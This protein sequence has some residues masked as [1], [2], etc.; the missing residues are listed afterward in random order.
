MICG[1]TQNA[2]Y[3]ILKQLSKRKL[4]NKAKHLGYPPK[5][6]IFST[7]QLIAIGSLIKIMRL[8]AYTV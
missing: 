1:I 4:G 6:P 2:Y 8:N 3:N 7:I 5:F